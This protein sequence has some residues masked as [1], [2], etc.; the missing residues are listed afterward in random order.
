[1]VHATSGTLLVIS[2]RSRTGQ[3]L[4]QK[5]ALLG[6]PTPVLGPGIGAPK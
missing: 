4:G 6:C 1:M 2:A 3:L 5:D